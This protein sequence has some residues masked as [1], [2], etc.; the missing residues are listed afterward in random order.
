[1]ALTKVMRSHTNLHLW[2]FL[3]KTDIKNSSQVYN[4]HILR[5]TTDF[6]SFKYQVNMSFRINVLNFTIYI[7]II[8]VDTSGKFNLTILG[9]YDF[10][11]TNR[12]TILYK[13]HAL[14]TEPIKQMTD[15]IQQEIQNKQTER[16]KSRFRVRATK[17]TLMKLSSK[18]HFA[19]NCWRQ[20]QILKERKC[21]ESCKKSFLQLLNKKWRN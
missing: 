6:F 4:Y 9:Y 3:T 16:A 7:V 8:S 2:S 12:L 19:A 10:K 5:A 13:S 15:V 20:L 18:Y 1:M 11:Q 17:L 14:C 21:S